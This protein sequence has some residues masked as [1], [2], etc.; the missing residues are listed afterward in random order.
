MKL[1]NVTAALSVQKGLV[2]LNQVPFVQLQD[3]KGNLL[4]AADLL[5]A[6]MGD[7]VLVTCEKAHAVLGTN[8]PADALVLC[9]LS[10]KEQ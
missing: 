8:N 1:C 10:A 4:V 2:E 3:E 7:Q 6:Q 5:G 9:I